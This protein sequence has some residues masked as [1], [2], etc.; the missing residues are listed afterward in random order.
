MGSSLKGAYKSTI[1]K[2]NYKSKLIN[3]EN[4]QA[5]DMLVTNK[6]PC[7]LEHLH[8]SWR[9]CNIACLT[10]VS[11]NYSSASMF[12][13]CFWPNKGGVHYILFPFLYLSLQLL[14]GCT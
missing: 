14:H 11:Y 12:F 7:F 4:Q 8:I 1:Y 9:P 2:E 5:L 10:M 13:P 3:N 6:G